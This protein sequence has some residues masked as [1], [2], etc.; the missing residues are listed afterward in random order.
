MSRRDTVRSK[1]KIALEARAKGMTQEAAAQ[2]AETTQQQVSRWEETER[3]T[4]GSEW[5]RRHGGRPRTA[6]TDDQ[7]AEAK[8]RLARGE[9]LASLGREFGISP[10]TVARWAGKHQERDGARR[11]L[12]QERRTLRQRELRDFRVDVDQTYQA[13]HYM[14]HLKAV[15]LFRM[16][17]DRRPLNAEREYGDRVLDE[18]LKLILADGQYESLRDGVAATER[19]CGRLRVLLQKAENP[20]RIVT[21]LED[22]TLT[23]D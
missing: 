7:V 15:Y 9:T 12:T 19:L 1:R 3:N 22:P 11:R 10:S 13:V 21:H 16:G 8:R 2:L 14:R 23:D 20:F 17:F 6:L 5:T 4:T 18:A